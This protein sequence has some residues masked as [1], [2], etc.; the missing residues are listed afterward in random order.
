MCF[1]KRYRHTVLLPVLNSV[2]CIYKDYNRF[3]NGL[4]KKQ[5]ANK[6]LYDGSSLTGDTQMFTISMEINSGDILSICCNEVE[7]IEINN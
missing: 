5:N 6:E 4:R 3:I 2:Q 7:V 1:G